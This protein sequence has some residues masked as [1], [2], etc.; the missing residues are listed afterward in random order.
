M[1][2]PQ[3]LNHAFNRRWKFAW[4]LVADDV[5]C[6]CER[7]PEGPVV[8]HEVSELEVGEF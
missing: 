5:D 4:N 2:C 1:R 6:S 8:Y 7:Q 3:M